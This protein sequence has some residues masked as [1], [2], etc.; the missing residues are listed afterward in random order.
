MELAGFLIQV[1]GA[2]FTAVGL[3][4]AW[5]RVS[6][7]STQWRKGIGDFINGLLMR[8]KKGSGDIVI[9]PRGAVITAVGGT[10]EV[11]VEPDSPERRLRQLEDESKSLQKRVRRTEKAVKRIDQAVD[12]V[13]STINAALAKLV[14]DDNL[15]KVSDIRLALIGLGISF[16][17][18][19]IEHGPLLQRVFCAAQ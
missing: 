11:I 12:E 1:F 19:V 10:P 3:L 8:S 13:D 14:S 18:F 15:I 16:V 6:N 4:I 9:T 5:E 2:L 17:G 7:R